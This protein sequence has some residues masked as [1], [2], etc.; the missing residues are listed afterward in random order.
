MCEHQTLPPAHF[1]THTHNNAR[2]ALLIIINTRVLAF[3]TITRSPRPLACDAHYALQ[4]AACPFRKFISI[5]R[6]CV[7]A[8]AHNAGRSARRGHTLLINALKDL[9]IVDC[10]M[11][12]KWYLSPA[13]LATINYIRAYVFIYIRRSIFQLTLLM[14]FNYSFIY[15][16]RRETLNF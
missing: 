9:P 8:S 2:A 13:S 3:F 10:G 7:L 5:K 12:V 1:S 16:S 6:P 4:I 15:G 14:L 11:S